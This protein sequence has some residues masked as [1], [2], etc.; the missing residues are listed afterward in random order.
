M[1]LQGIWSGTISFSLVAIPVQLVKA[2]DSGRVSFR[3]LH[4]KD[5][6][7][8]QR[9]MFCPEEEKMVP[10]DEIIRGYEIGQDRYVLVTDEE[11][12]SVSPERSRTIEII[13]FIDMEEVDPIYYDHPYYLTPLKGGEK[14]YRLLVDVMRRTKKA[15]LAKF[16]LGEREYLVAV[17]SAEGVLTLITLHYSEEILPDDDISPKEEKMEAQEKNRIKQ[18]IK[19]MMSDFEPEKY[20]DRRRKKITEIIRKRVKEK[21]PV[22][23][24][25]VEEEEGE[26]PADLVAALKE[27]MLKVKKKR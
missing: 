10:P 26:G 21:A 19:K 1:A 3:L 18:T 2:V 4:G 14:A 24:P 7:P 6:S 8:L 23:A 27:S 11:L 13:E 16:V 15:G 5:Y 9:R 22:E 20:A 17:K 12:E 25:Q